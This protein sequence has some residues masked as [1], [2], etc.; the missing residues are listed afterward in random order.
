MN[1]R[2]D[3]TMLDREARRYGLVPLGDR[4]AGLRVIDPF[5]IDKWLDRFRRGKRKLADLCAHYGANLDDAHEAGSDAIAA[6]RL[7]WVI[8]KR[9]E[10]Q[11]RYP[12]VVQLRAT[13][14]RIRDDLDELHAAQVVMARDQAASLAAYFARQ[15]RTEHVEPAWPVV[16]MPAAELAA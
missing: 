9:G 6:G 1:A 15:G 8:G 2:F 16:P 10:V 5:V 12:E 14:K 3:L 11:A 13:W 4:E 7:A